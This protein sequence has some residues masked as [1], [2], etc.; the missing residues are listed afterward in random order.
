[1]DYRLIVTVISD[2]EHPPVNFAL[3]VPDELA[4][5]LMATP[6]KAVSLAVERAGGMVIDKSKLLEFK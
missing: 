1:M 2:Q 6:V 5:I 3:Q 4:L